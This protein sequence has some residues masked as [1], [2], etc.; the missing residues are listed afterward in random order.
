[1]KNINILKD[2]KTLNKL[3]APSVESHTTKNGIVDF[4]CDNAGYVDYC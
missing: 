3:H 2:L 4:A 1:M